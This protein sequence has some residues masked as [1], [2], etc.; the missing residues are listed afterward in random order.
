ML[1][2]LLKQ[3]YDFIYHPIDISGNVLNQLEESLND[4]M[5]E[6]NTRPK[7]GLYFDALA[8]LKKSDHKKI[9]LFLGSNI[10]NLDDEQAADF[11]Y[12]L[13]SN[14]RHDD[15]LLLG[16]DLKKS[17]DIILPAY[18]DPQG[19]TASFNLN[20]LDRINRELGG[21]F[22]RN[23]FSHAPE[24]LEDKGVANSFLISLAEQSVY[25]KSLD[26][27]FNFTK[28]E[29]IHTEISRK[30]D[31]EILQRIIADTDFFLDA[32]ICDSKAYF[33][34]YILKRN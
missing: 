6:L 1:K 2:K 3:N 13:G 32:K 26:K 10:G 29:K 8:S 22:E 33:A 34:D 14:F 16:V 12:H 19:I 24:Y 27:T 15:I 21:N 31:E 20:I 4:E 18:N 30:Y 25:I 17:R 28:G 9:V 7:Q 11:L 23:N 5:P